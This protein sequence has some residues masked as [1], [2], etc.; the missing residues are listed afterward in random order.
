MAST[1]YIPYRAKK[2]KFYVNGDTKF[3]GK[4]C[5]VNPKRTR[6]FD[7]FLQELT[8]NLKTTRP[9]RNICTPVGGHRVKDLEDLVNNG[10]YVAVAGD[11]FKKVG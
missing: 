4:Q 10:N 7:A 2:C 6:N 11:K 8:N 9:I 3:F 5:V 1:A